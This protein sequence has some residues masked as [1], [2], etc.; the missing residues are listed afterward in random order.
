MTNTLDRLFRDQIAELQDFEEGCERLFGLM[1]KAAE[2]PE[3]ARY[4]DQCASQSGERLKRLAPL[5]VRFDAA[6]R[7]L[8]APGKDM[9]KRVSAQIEA[10]ED[11]PEIDI[12][13]LS[14]MQTALYAQEARYW[15]A[16]RMAAALG[17]QDLKALLV[18]SHDQ[19]SRGR[20]TRWQHLEA[21]SRIRPQS[22]FAGVAALA[23]SHMPSSATN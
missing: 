10:C 21:A 4:L 11:E 14:A 8:N 23:A 2:A 5:A 7:A 16:A 1:A 13:I 12:A 17:R 6:G 3:I 19:I 18:A 22:E 15:A 20:S 9:V